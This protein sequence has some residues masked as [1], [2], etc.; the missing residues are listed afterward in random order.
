MHVSVCAVLCCAVS[1]HV[2]VLCPS[3]AFMP[4]VT[5]MF[6]NAALGLLTH[7]QQS[8]WLLTARVAVSGNSHILYMWKLSGA[9]LRS[10]NSGLHACTLLRGHGLEL[11]FSHAVSSCLVY[12]DLNF[13]FFRRQTQDRGLHVQVRS[14]SEIARNGEGAAQ[15]CARSSS[16]CR[17]RIKGERLLF[18]YVEG[19]ELHHVPRFNTT[20]TLEWKRLH[21]LFCNF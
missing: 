9:P 7:A 11:T 17:L 18:P 13:F 5:G 20:V 21:F 14:Q 15:D 1:V 6:W 10:P 16:G 12:S 4:S 3:T 8:H 2:G 19:H